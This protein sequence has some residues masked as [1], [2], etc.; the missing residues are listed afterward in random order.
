M[1]YEKQTV[2]PRNHVGFVV[3]AK[4]PVLTLSSEPRIRRVTDLMLAN[5]ADNRTLSE[6]AAQIGASERTLGRLFLRH[7]GMSFGAWRRRLR[8]LEAID[9]LGNGAPMTEVAYELGYSSPSAFIAMFRENLGEPPAGF[10]S[11]RL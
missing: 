1:N 9:R 7:L 8:L 3:D 2:D 5:P 4:R 11:G 10:F 6:W